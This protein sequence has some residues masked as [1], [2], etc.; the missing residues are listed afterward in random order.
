L[1]RDASCA[2]IRT[3]EAPTQRRRPKEKSRMAAVFTNPKA[4]LG[5]RRQRARNSS[6]QF[7]ARIEGSH[8]E[9]KRCARCGE[10]DPNVPSAWAGHWNCDDCGGNI[11]SRNVTNGSGSL[12]GAARRLKFAKIRNRNQPAPHPINE[13]LKREFRDGPRNLILKAK[14]LAPR[15]DN[16][17]EEAMRLLG[18][19]EADIIRCRESK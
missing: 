4:N 7:N 2:T 18:L 16:K 6:A 10:H 1:T 15:K 13:R 9:G 5:K 19:T 17:R 14:I 3:V 11:V 8:D 12:P